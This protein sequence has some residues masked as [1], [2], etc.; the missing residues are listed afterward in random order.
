[1]GPPQVT[2]PECGAEPHV[3]KLCTH[4]CTRQGTENAETTI[5]AEIA[6]I[7]EKKIY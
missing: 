2:E 6:E 5:N 7:T 1:M 3:I 4:A